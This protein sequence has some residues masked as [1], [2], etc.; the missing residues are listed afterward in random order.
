[1]SQFLDIA[2]YDPWIERAVTNLTGYFHAADCHVYILEKKRAVIGFALI[3]RHLRFST[4]GHAVAEFHIQKEYERN[5]HG[6]RLAEYVFEQFRGNW[7]VAVALKNKP[8]QAFWEQV[9]SSFTGGRFSREVNTSFNGLGLIFNTL[10][11]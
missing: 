8:A 2:H 5:G 10:K 1:M 3:N 6:R 4:D 7:E 11:Q 9:V